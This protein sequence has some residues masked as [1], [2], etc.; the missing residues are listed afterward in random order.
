MS[1]STFPSAAAEL[2]HEALE[3]KKEHSSKERQH[4][5]RQD[6]FEV[7]DVDCKVVLG[8]K[9][10]EVLDYS[11]FGLAIF[12]ED[13]QSIQ[14]NYPEVPFIIE[15]IE[16]ARLHICKVR[17][18][19]FNTG[20]KVAFE[21]I[22]EPLNIVRITAILSANQIIDEHTG[23]IEFVN[24]VPD[25]VCKKVYE[26][27]DSL[28]HLQ[29]MV[30]TLR[31]E[32]KHE[33]VQELTIFESTVAEV[34]SQHLKAIFDPTYED[35]AKLLKNA[36]EKDLKASFE[37]FRTKLRHLIHQ[38]KLAERFYNK[39]LGYAGDFGMMN[40][41]YRNEEFGD[42]LFSKCL[43]R[44]FMEHPF[45]KAVRNRADFLS[46]KLVGFVREAKVTKPMSFL[47]VAAGPAFEIQSLLQKQLDLTNVQF[48][49]LDQDLNALRE[50][51]RSLRS[52][53][54][55]L[56]KEINIKY[57]HKA[58][59]NIFK[60]S[61]SQKYD[62]VYSAGLFDY[63]SD[64]VATGAAKRLFDLLKP[65]GQLIIGNFTGADHSKIMMELAFDWHL[66]YRTEADLTRLYKDIGPKMRVES[67][68]E[69][70][71]LFV[72]IENT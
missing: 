3:V 7:K 52:I 48:H 41:I 21:I 14:N 53:S 58:I 35:F 10:Y 51:Q 66:I 71:N 39:P 54:R 57:L 8:A 30:E 18:Q 56:G 59:R 16:V 13:S 33:S 23:Q 49:L 6:R 55:T 20:M 64:A 11:T 44:Y 36:P 70:V 68:P 32:T 38:S 40:F 15:N 42:S 43:H 27:K 69:G 17:Q 63:F 12:V 29:D 45:G 19:D 9:Q 4:V 34:V 28:E 46:N 24:S 1:N 26:I 47:S 62:L 2:P 37:F 61:S 60:D 22:G 31:E 25:R 50:A 5:V 72:V 67:E 65:G